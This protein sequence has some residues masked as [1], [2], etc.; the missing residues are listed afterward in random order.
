MTLG[1]TMTMHKRFIQT[2]RTTIA[3]TASLILIGSLASD[4]SAQSVKCA[5]SPALGVL[6][7]NGDGT[8]SIGEIRSADPNNAELQGLAS[9]LEAKG[10]SGIQYVG[11]DPSIDGTT[12]EGG[13][14]SGTTTGGGTDNGTTTGGG[15]GNNAAPGTG[16]ANGTANGDG[17]GSGTTTG[18]GPNNNSTTTPGTATSA[19]KLPN[20]GERNQAT[21]ENMVASGMMAVTASGLAMAGTVAWVT[22]HGS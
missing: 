1:R 11:C 19:L 9:Q 7:S 6:D 16:A 3:A 20:T 12:T 22:E 15:T 13:A 10:I 14:S 2:L 4:A 18:G 5:P 17:T 21:S 8:L